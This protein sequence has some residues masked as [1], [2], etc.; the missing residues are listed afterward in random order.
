MACASDF[1]TFWLLEK[2]G[3]LVVKV[4]LFLV[5]CSGLNQYVQWNRIADSK[6]VGN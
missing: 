5:L 3:Y 4:A 2:Y 1:R 6:G